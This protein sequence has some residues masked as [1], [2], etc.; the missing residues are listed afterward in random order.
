MT[1]FVL[2]LSAFL[3]GTTIQAQEK[4]RVDISSPTDLTNGNPCAIS[5]W[6]GNDLLDNMRRQLEVSLTSTRGIDIVEAER[7]R[8]YRP[9]RDSQVETVFKNRLTKNSQFSIRPT[10]QTFNLCQVT[11]DNQ[12]SMKASVAIQ[13]S[14]LN[15]ADGK[16]VDSFVAE[17]NTE[18]MIDGAKL[19]MKGVS[20]GSGLFKDSAVGKAMTIALTNAS[21]GIVKRLPALA[22][23]AGDVN[24]QILKKNTP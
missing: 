11:I 3:M 5:A 7:M 6:W 16:T 4:L 10:L 12:I 23:P 21:D 17:S 19:D 22:T 20:L 14:I 2:F 18:D 1:R 15:T 8:S 9:A 24:V 13:I